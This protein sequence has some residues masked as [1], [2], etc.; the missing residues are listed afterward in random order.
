MSSNRKG[1]ARTRRGALLLASG[2][3][4][5]T[6]AASGSA[7]AAGGG[8]L[9]KGATYKGRTS[10]HTAVSFKLSRSG[11]AVL[12][13]A[14]RIGYDGACGQG[15]GPVYD[16]KVGSM[17]LSKAGM[18]VARAEGKF[19]SSAIKLKPIQLLVVGRVTGRSAH[20][21]VKEMGASCQSG[22]GDPYAETFRARAG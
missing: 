14:T 4:C 7:L 13:F 15:G 20:G 21:S 8:K 3:C 16:V 19:P 2:A 11:G 6:L 10:E 22:K 5:A 9:A 17:R 1:R 18:F 12:S